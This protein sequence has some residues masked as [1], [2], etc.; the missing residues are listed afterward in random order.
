M[1]RPLVEHGSILTCGLF[2][3]YYSI[4]SL[5]SKSSTRISLSRSLRSPLARYLTTFFS[6]LVSAIMHVLTCPHME[7]CM[8]I[9]EL[10]IH[11]GTAGAVLLEDCAIAS[12][13]YI[14]KV[15]MRCLNGSQEKIRRLGLATEDAV[16][17]ASGRNNRTVKIRRRV[18]AKSRSAPAME[19]RPQK[20]D[21]AVLGVG[22][23]STLPALHWR[24]LGYF[25]VGAFWTWSIS[26]LMYSL[27]NC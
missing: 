14:Y 7:I 3:L 19:S 4:T 12:Y 20:E 9:P 11:L 21:N 6:F 5:I 26:N 13:G 16:E 24:A 2:R 23:K 15:I 17:V 25:W 22:N 8:I 18:R 1:R 27:Y 10:W